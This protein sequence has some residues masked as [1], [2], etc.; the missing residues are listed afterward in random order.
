MFSN[1][2]LAAETALRRGVERVAIIDWDVHVG[3]GAE[4]I[5]WDRE[6]VLAVSLHQQDWYPAH[7]GA[8]DATGGPGAEGS[9]VNIPLPPATSSASAAARSASARKPAADTSIR[10]VGS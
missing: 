5:F 2:A 1:T 10:P 9:T 4:R 6:E 7:A 8:L 3:N